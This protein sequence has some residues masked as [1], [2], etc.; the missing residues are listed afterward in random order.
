M[1]Q[2]FL[3]HLAIMYWDKIGCLTSSQQ[4]C[5]LQLKMKT[6][7]IPTCSFISS[8]NHWPEIKFLTADQI[9]SPA[10]QSTFSSPPFSAMN[11][12]ATP[13]KLQKNNQREKK[14]LFQPHCC[15]FNMRFSWGNISYVVSIL[16]PQLCMSN[17][18]PGMSLHIQ[19]FYED[20]VNKHQAYLLDPANK[21]QSLQLSR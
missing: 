20:F 16:V 19:D 2:Y 17:L 1:L 10:F 3:I 12:V 8:Q 21:G 9:Q 13:H 4:Q 6:M 14:P 5:S 18:V 15:T 11:R 7:V